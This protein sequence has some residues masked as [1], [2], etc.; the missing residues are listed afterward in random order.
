MTSQLDMYI[1][2]QAKIAS[3]YNGKIIAVKDGEVIGTYS[4]KY[5]A[6]KDMQKKISA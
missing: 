6:W 3:E 4:D 5:L 2:N 1:K